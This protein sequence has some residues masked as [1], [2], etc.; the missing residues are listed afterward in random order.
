MNL[1]VSSHAMMNGL[2]KE[3]WDGKVSA[4]LRIQCDQFSFP[5]DDAL[6]FQYWENLV[7]E[8]VLQKHP[9]L[10]FVF[11]GG[12]LDQVGN[13]SLE[14]LVEKKREDKAQAIYEKHDTELPRYKTEEAQ[15]EHRKKLIEHRN[16]IFDS[17]RVLSEAT[18][19]DWLKAMQL[20]K[21]ILWLNEAVIELTD[22]VSNKER[23]PILMSAYNELSY[24]CPQEVLDK[25]K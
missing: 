12:E 9:K 13:Y 24:F 15:K 10:P 18:H 22:Q 11:S 2:L 1:R 20:I 3:L 16:V 21:S 23:I 17:A 5:Y 6:D 7:M 25:V 14:R 4:V 19:D 8:Q